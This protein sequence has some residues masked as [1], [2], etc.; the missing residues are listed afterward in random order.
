MSEGPTIL[1]G[2]LKGKKVKSNDG[3]DLGKIDKVSQNHFRLE[4]GS[5]KKD[6]FWVPKY[7]SDSFDG[8]TLWLLSSED[9]VRSTYQVG[10]EPSAEQFQQD[11]ESFKR[12]HGKGKSWDTNQVSFVK[13]RTRGVASKPKNSQ[14]DYKN[15]RDLK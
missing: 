11:L 3:K 5:I 4:K 1:W 2:Q 6:K 10:K 8:K 12:S 9:E 14:E 13:E 7:F 15:V